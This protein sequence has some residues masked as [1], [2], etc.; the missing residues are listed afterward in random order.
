MFK[1]ITQ[2]NLSL[3]C[4]YDFVESGEWVLQK[5]HS[6]KNIDNTS[7][8]QAHINLNKTVELVFLIWAKHL[9]Q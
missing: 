4:V 1:T 9:Y 3:L 7:A 8:K 5:T 6:I 2:F